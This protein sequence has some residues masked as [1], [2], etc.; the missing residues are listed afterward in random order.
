MT[1]EAPVCGCDSNLGGEVG[2]WKFT[3]AP[4]MIAEAH[5]AGGAEEALGT[6]ERTRG[7]HA[8]SA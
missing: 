7:C 4:I 5:S 1:G 2:R 8:D 3:G 6:E